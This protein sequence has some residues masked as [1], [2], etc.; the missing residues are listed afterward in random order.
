MQTVHNGDVVSSQ[1]VKSSSS[2]FIIMSRRRCG[3]LN[4]AIKY[5]CDEWTRGV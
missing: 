3:W 2:L 1:L 5:S 4:A